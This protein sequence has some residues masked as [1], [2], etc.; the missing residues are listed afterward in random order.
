MTI[1]GIIRIILF[2]LA[3]LALILALRSLMAGVRS[4]SA[5]SKQYFNVGR[6]EAQRQ[7]FA[8]MLS[9]VGLVILALVF[10]IVATLIPDDLFG[11]ASLEDN[12]QPT[13]DTAQ[14]VGL[15]TVDGSDA[16][17]ESVA[18][19]ESGSMG[20][21]ADGETGSPVAE[22]TAPPTLI[23]TETPEPTP[24]LKIVYV[25]SPIVGLYIRDLPDG[26]IIDVL[27][28]QTELRVLEES[29]TISETVWIKVVVADG[30]EGWVAE[31][32]TTEVTPLN[33]LN[34]PAPSEEPVEAEN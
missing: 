31:S 9:T 33:S 34:E 27:D 26:D 16:P 14:V 8:N 20:T 6:L 10:A 30:R 3:G 2:I 18:E 24:E 29:E 21:V 22:T 12:G 25:N 1:A 32:F 13:S 11:S 17:S 4:R 19:S 5:A 7:V 23:P 28:D 15:E